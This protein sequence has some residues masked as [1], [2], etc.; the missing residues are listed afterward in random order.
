M[1]QEFLRGLA[2]WLGILEGLASWSGLVGL[3]WGKGWQGALLAFA[4]LRR[5][6]PKSLPLLAAMPFAL[7]AQVALATVR[8]VG[9]NP[10]L[11]LRPGTYADRTIQRLD[12]LGA[13]G[14]VPALHIVPNGG[15]KVAVCV[16]HGSG[17]D[18]TFYVWR[19]V[20]HLV[21]QGLAVL[22][23]D[24]DGHGENPRPQAFPTI[25][26][27]VAA[28][29][30][31]L[32]THYARVALLGTSLGGSVVARAAAEGAPCDALV[33]WAAPPHL[34]LTPTEYRRTQVTEA[35][36]IFRPPLLHL[37]RDGSL[38]HV[39]RAWQT[40]GIRAQLGTWDLFA[41][42]DLVGSLAALRAHPTRPP[43]LLVY[44][45]RDAVLR[46][47]AAATV[48]QASTA[49]ATFHLVRRA[50]HVSLAIEPETI[51]VTT[52]WLGVHLT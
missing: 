45:G 15:A 1:N 13:N 52:R 6:R 2:L 20:D 23:V 50:S 40:S 36:R 4:A 14:P 8:R 21:A 26:E 25:I 12:I 47:G 51:R 30:R 34:R 42:L 10:L 18:K 43:L 41:A 9:L 29:A 7:G 3:S 5:G 11:R 32:R 31:W 24:L 16:A 22:L 46:P 49:W 33:I 17:C 35:L 19:L 48:R 27:S 38:Y 39:V 37:F 28:P 44:A